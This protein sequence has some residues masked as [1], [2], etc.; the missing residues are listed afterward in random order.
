M[1]KRYLQRGLSLCLAATFTL[2]MLGAIQQLA[3]VE[4]APPAWAQQTSIRA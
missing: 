2:A 1:S 3:A 4:E